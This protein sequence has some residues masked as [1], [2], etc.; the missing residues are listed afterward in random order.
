MPLRYLQH[1]GRSTSADMMSVWIC[2]WVVDNI[3][4]N[5]EALRTGKYSLVNAKT[6]L[7]ERSAVCDGYACLLVDLLR[8][9]GLQANH[10]RGCG[11]GISWAENRKTLPTSNH[12]WVAVKLEGLIGDPGV[13][14]PSSAPSMA[15]GSP[16]TTENSGSSTPLPSQF[17]WCLIDPCWAAGSGKTQAGRLVF[18]KEYN[19]VYFLTRPELFVLDHLPLLDSDAWQLLPP[20]DIVSSASFKASQGRAK[21]GWRPVTHPS[22]SITL[23]AKELNQQGLKIRLELCM[24]MDKSGQS[25]GLKLYRAVTGPGGTHSRGDLLGSVNGMDGVGA[26]ASSSFQLDINLIAGPPNS[27]EYSLRCS[28]AA[29]YLSGSTF[30]LEARLGVCTGGG[31]TSVPCYPSEAVYVLHIT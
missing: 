28:W 20:A 16:R 27:L 23:S 5:F 30:R 15:T 2:R 18:N 1:C 22:T 10:V 24:P 21:Y 8:Q 11:K 4:Y 13:Y 7:K 31:D 9:A 25:L 17:S 14:D 29:N 3:S 6:V 19:D 26:T 12:A